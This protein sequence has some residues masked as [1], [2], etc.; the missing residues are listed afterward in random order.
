MENNLTIRN[1]TAADAPMVASIIRKM[2]VEEM[3]ESGGYQI[4]SD[5]KEWKLFNEIIIKNI[6]DKD[7]IYKIAESIGE[8]RTIIGISEAKMINRAFI[9][10]PTVVLHIH[11][12]YVDPPYRHKGIGKSLLEAIIEWGKEMKCEEVELDVLVNNP[13]QAVYAKLGFRTFEYKM[14]RKIY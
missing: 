14:V 4:S 2:M 13:A 10:H 8:K 7:F 11:S 5:E 9:F 6:N 3:E 12:L 1:A